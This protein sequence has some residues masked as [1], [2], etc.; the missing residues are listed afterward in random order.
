M[1]V[2]FL[3]GSGIP[4]DIANQSLGTVIGGVTGGPNP[5]AIAGVAGDACTNGYD[6]RGGKHESVD[7]H[8]AD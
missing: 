1:I 3:A 8:A 5:P 6:K 4:V 2:R 7:E